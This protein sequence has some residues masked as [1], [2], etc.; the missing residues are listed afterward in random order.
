MTVRH[1]VYGWLD[2]LFRCRVEWI[3]DRYDRELMRDA[4]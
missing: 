4:R 1:F 2:A 3:C